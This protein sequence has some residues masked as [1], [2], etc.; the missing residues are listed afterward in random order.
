[1]C[2]KTSYFVVPAHSHRTGD[3]KTTT[4]E[5]FKRSTSMIPCRYKSRGEQCPFGH[6]CFYLHLDDDGR[7]TKPLEQKEWERQQK[8]RER[9]AARARR[10]VE[11]VENL[12]RLS[13]SG[14]GFDED[15]AFDAEDELLSAVLLARDLLMD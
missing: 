3:D 1:M 13:V 6:R 10:H 8:N 15:L 12:L 5:R 2:R 7:D 4:I 14:N 9:R 11:F